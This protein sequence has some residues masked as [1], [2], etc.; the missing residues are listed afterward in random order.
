MPPGEEIF[1]RV[2]VKPRDELRRQ[3]GTAT[4]DAVAAVGIDQNFPR[5]RRDDPDLRR[6]AVA[7]AFFLAPEGAE[8]IVRGDNLDGQIRH[9]SLDALVGIHGPM[10]VSAEVVLWLADDPGQPPLADGEI[11]GGFQREQASEGAGG[12]W[13]EVS[14]SI[15]LAG[16]HRNG[17]VFDGKLNSVDVGSAHIDFPHARQ[18]Q[19]LRAPPTAPGRSGRERNFR[20]KEFA[21]RGPVGKDTVK[22]V[23]TEVFGYCL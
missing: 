6:T 15:R 9:K 13:R 10:S 5:F 12:D 21:N 20:L 3:F 8:R 2:A 19:E 7:V 22:T 16:S 17:V 1:G 18:A 4:H 14:T 11:T 23:A